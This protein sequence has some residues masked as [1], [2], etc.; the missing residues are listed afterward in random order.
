VK[1]KCCEEACRE[2][3]KSRVRLRDLCLNESRK[4]WKTVW[5]TFSF[6]AVRLKN[7]CSLVLKVC[8]PK[9]LEFSKK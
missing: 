1:V 7:D 3:A 8:R 9:N 4:T 2:L 6:L 5:T